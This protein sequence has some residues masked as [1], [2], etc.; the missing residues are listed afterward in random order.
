MGS[1]TSDAQALTSF[2]LSKRI[3]LT[4]CVLCL[5]FASIADYFLYQSLVSKD[6]GLI[7]ARMQ[8]YQ[9]ILSHA[10]LDKLIEVIE[11]EQV[12]SELWLIEISDPRG[13][14]FTNQN[15]SDESLLRLTDPRWPVL[16]TEKNRWLVRNEV[17]EGLSFTL[18]LGSLERQ[19]Q[20]VAY[21]W[22]MLFT[23]LPLILISLF[24]MHRIHRH[25][26]HPL[27]DFLRT[28][29][30]MQQQTDLHQRFRVAEPDTELGQLAEQTNR[31]LD[32]IERLFNGM[33]ASLDNVAHDLRT[34]LARQRLRVEQL[35]MQPSV[36]NDPQTFEALATI[37][38]ESE[39]IEKMLT[40][41]MDISQAETGTLPLNKQP[42]DPEAI[43]L[44]AIEV[45][46]FIAEDKGCEIQLKSC[47]PCTLVADEL[48]LRQVLLNLLDNA[49]KFSP[50]NS[51]I[52][53]SIRCTDQHTIIS[54]Q[55]Q[56]CG[57]SEEDL[58]HIFDRLYRGD[59]SRGSKGL[60][61]GLSLVKAVIEAHGGEL[62]VSSTTEAPTGSCFT[63]SLPAS[64]LLS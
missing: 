44:Q 6:F 53:L 58:P 11:Q 10:G 59:K 8:N 1:S 15:L 7:D 48:R 61:L 17:S 25:A 42:L 41:L 56:G 45:Y 13:R 46:S 28:S 39:R 12:D 26:L 23:L 27:R 22:A 2:Q 62:R 4:L 20:Q 35:L 63:V 36:Q 14:R 32:T 24:L 52:E 5:F 57:I 64:G 19:E 29:Q 3:G 21:R 60:G 30:Q 50:E 18:G 47:A 55:D 9:R 37:S 51:R 43:A 40:T 16:N 31:F 34:P 49:L 33:Q 54:V 38:E